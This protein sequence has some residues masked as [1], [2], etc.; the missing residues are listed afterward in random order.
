M[1]TFCWPVCKRPSSSSCRFLA[2]VSDEE[3][4]EAAKV[5]DVSRFCVASP[6]PILSSVRT[7]FLPR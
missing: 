5:S 1:D 4:C 3:E 6:E 2:I 7:A